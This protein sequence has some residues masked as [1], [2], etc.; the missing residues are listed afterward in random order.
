MFFSSGM[1]RVKIQ[2][3][4]AGVQGRSIHEPAGVQGRLRRGYGT[5]GSE[6]HG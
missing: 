2:S 4:P 3:E 1:K 6:G 5:S